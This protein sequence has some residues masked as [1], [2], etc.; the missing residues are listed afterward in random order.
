MRVELAAVLICCAVIDHQIAAVEA[1]N[2]R[3]DSAAHLAAKYAAELERIAPCR[4]EPRAPG[5][6][7]NI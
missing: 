4:V 3:A 7:H 1:A 5:A 6:G 2:R